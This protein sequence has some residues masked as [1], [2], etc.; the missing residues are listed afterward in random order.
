MK[1]ILGK[2]L[3]MTQVWQGDNVLAVTRVRTGPCPIVQIKT[4]AKDGYEAVQVGFGEKKEKNI[5][6]PQRG[7]LR[8]VRAALPES[9]K[10]S[11]FGLRYL[12][13]FRC[14]SKDLQVG[15]IIDINTFAVGD[16]VDVV[17][18]SKGLGFQGVVKR[19]GFKGHGTTHGTKDAVRMPGSIGASGPAHVFKGTRMGGH[20]GDER[21]MVKNLEIIGIDKE[22][23]IILVKGAL[24][25]ARNSLVSIQG[26]GELK[27]VVKQ[28]AGE[29]QP[30]TADN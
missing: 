26:A 11:K 15:D 23:N 28:A 20:M 12:K 5:S 4:K 6:K 9:E 10:N 19:Y 25:G 8:K 27:I 22:N 3:D 2:K 18:I 13:E 7:H 29:A 17:G 30:K 21:V 14:G 1:F 16:T 24:P